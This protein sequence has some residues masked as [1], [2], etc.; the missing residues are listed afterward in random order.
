M[1]GTGLGATVMQVNNANSFMFSWTYIYFP[2]VE[3]VGKKDMLSG[4]GKN[5]EEK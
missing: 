4:C 2:L 5:Y 1:L 3:E